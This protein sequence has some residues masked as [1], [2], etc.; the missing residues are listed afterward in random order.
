MEA[1][2]TSVFAVAIAEIG[3]KTQ[4]LALVLAARFGK[5]WSITFGVLLATVANHALAAW[6]GKE[7]GGFFAGPWLDWVLGIGF[8]AAGLWLLVPDKVDDDVD[9]PSR[10]GPFLTTLVAFFCVEM[11]DKTQVATIGLGARF[12]DGFLVAFGTTLGMMAANLPVI[13]FGEK[14]AHALPLVWMRRIAAAFF[15]FIGLS[16]LA[17]A[18]HLL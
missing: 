8:I 4:L 16:L 3:D 10:F 1:F 7:L 2:L 18:A 6:A 5:P 17:R 9:R 15:A 13:F 14:A 11:G 12:D